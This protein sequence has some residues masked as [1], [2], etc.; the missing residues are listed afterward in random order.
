MDVDVGMGQGGQT[1]PKVVY[2][3]KIS[4]GAAGDRR[5]IQPGPGQGCPEHRLGQD[6]FSEVTGKNF[7][8]LCTVPAC[9]G[10]SLVQSSRGSGSPRLFSSGYRGEE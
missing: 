4:G 7:G 2:S 8:S 10:H 5:A 1:S 6:P 9:A 3:A